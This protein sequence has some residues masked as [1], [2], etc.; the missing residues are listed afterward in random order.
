[1]FPQIL[2]QMEDVERSC[3]VSQRMAKGPSRF[4]LILTQND[5]I[6][7]RTLFC[8]L[9]TIE[10][11]AI[12]HIVD[13]DTNF[14]AAAFLNAMNSEEVWKVYQTIWSN[15]YAGHPV[16]LHVDSGP[17]F[18]SN[19]FRNPCQLVGISLNICGV[20][21]HNSIGVGER[22]HSF[23]R[24]IYLKVAREHPNI[25]NGAALEIAVRVLNDTAGPN[26]LLQT[27]LVF[28]LMPQMPIRHM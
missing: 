4:C 19:R 11:K 14:N 1:M 16:E 10:G 12:L 24:I 6:L 9:F 7:N 22:Y 8:N 27:L 23:L 17:P 13:R 3:D 15:R 26:G 20:E 2:Q 28:G 25:N 5:L 18:V 21:S